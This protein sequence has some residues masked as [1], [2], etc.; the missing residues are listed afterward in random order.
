MFGSISLQGGG[1]TANRARA[2]TTSLN[3]LTSPPS[4]N[5]QITANADLML[6]Q[7]LRR[8]PSIK[9]ALV[10]P[11]VF[12]NNSSGLISVCMLRSRSPKLAQF[13]N[14]NSVVRT[15]LGELLKQYTFK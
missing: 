6:G 2:V 1:I 10:Q 12:A 7:R 13:L 15:V 3:I 8:W 11:P 5:S 9:P 4:A 14:D